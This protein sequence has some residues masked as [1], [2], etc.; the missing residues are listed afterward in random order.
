MDSIRNVAVV[1]AKME[2]AK[3][4]EKE[5]TEETEDDNASD[6]SHCYIFEQSLQTINLLILLLLRGEGF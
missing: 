2:S 5:E 4:D 6:V 1:I 3:R